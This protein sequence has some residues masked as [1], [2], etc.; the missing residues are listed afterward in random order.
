M[1]FYFLN[2]PLPYGSTKKYVMIYH[3]LRYFHD[4]GVFMS[5]CSPSWAR[6]ES[7]GLE[8][9]ISG[10]ISAYYCTFSRK[11]IVG[12]FLSLPWKWWC[13][14]EKNKEE[15]HW[16]APL[17]TFND[18]VVLM[19]IFFFFSKRNCSSETDITKYACSKQKK[20]DVRT[21]Y[22]SYEEITE[23]WARRIYVWKSETFFRN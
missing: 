6:E 13:F 11:Q 16:A 5:N 4:L 17:A 22:I 19:F 8:F 1:V 23:K 21:M 15:E 14:L 2:L 7:L 9:R 18:A 12:K 3:A 20:K 10:R